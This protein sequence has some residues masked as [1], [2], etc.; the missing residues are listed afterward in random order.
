MIYSVEIDVKIPDGMDPDRLEDLKAR[1]KALSAGY[2]QS[3]ELRHLWRIAGKFGNLS[4]YDV[5]DHDRLHDILGSLPLFPYMTLRVVPLAH[6][7]MAI[8]QRPS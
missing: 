4:I 2:Q 6:H 3:G 1:E 5:A 7:P 8:E